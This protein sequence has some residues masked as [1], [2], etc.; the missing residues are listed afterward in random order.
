MPPAPYYE[1]AVRLCKE[2]PTL[3]VGLHL[4]VLATRTRPV[5]SPE[6]VP[7]I[8]TPQGFF[9]ENSEQLLNAN[10]R[11]EELERE[12]RA[13]IGK[14]RASGLQFVYLEEH[15]GTPPLVVDIIKKI[16]REERLIYG[17]G[18]EVCGYTRIK[19]QPQNVV[20]G[21]TLPDG[22][23]VHYAAPAFT[24]EVKQSFFDVL[25]SLE[26]GRWWSKSHPGGTGPKSDLTEL[27]CDPRTMEII[28]EKNIQLVSFKDL[29]EEEFGQTNKQ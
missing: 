4:T 10:P 11:P 3:A 6:E 12:I 17:E 22:H 25:S 28:K 21:H 16:C 7:S 27:L 15:R 29:W 14:A 8:V 2:N 26:H 13:Q 1:E 9:Y 23:I 19:L 20:I 5:L 18:A 24:E